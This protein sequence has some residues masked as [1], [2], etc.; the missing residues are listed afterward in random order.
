MRERGGGGGGSQ[1][2][3]PLIAISF[4]DHISTVNFSEEVCV[5]GGGGGGGGT[6]KGIKSLQSQLLVSDKEEGGVCVYGGGGGKYK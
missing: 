2:V 5:C 4:N 6:G 3:Q 1:I